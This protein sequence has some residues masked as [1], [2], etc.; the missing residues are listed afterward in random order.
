MSDLLAV[1]R[2]DCAWNPYDNWCEV[3]GPK[4]ESCPTRIYYESERA[5]R[6][7]ARTDKP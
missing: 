2:D 3:P 6:D 7:A 4:C 5:N 1:M